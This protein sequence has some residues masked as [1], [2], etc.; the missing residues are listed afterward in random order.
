MNYSIFKDTMAD[1]TYPEIEKA[2]EQKLPV[3]FP[4]A[5]IEEHGPHLCLGTDTYLTYQLCSNI[6]KDMKALGMD[7]VI[8]PPFYWGINIATGGFAGS[9]TVKPETMVSMLYD[10]LECLKNWGF[11]KVFFLNFHGDFKHN[12][13]IVDSARKA[14][15]EL[16]MGTY[17]VCP[18]FFLQRSG[19]SGKEP[20]I[21]VQPEE[22]EP[23]PP[24]APQP[25]SPYLDIHAG[26]FETSLMLKDF[27]DLV[28]VDLAKT[29]ESSRTTFEGLKTWQQGGEN[30]REITPLGY[31]GN[32]SNINL[33]H[34]EAFNRDM[35]QSISRAIYEFLKK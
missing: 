10:L 9:F 17:F 5:V 1:M 27:P 8:A 29:L 23:E 7:S 25:P 35:A 2:A 21:L 28:N 14:M 26:G 22:K 3:L 6:R 33:D 15:E 30:A 34:A 31:C 12:M 4:I 18:E 32:P 13:T 24:K 20:Y 16:G 11:E 19:L